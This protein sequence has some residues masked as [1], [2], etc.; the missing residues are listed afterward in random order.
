MTL[1]RIIAATILLNYSAQIDHFLNILFSQKHYSPHTIS[2]YKRD[3]KL[4]LEFT[5][6]TPPPPDDITHKDCKNFIYFLHEK[7]L[8]NRSIARVVAGLRSFWNHLIEEEHTVGNPWEALPLPKAKVGLPKV[9]NENQMSD[10]LESIG[11]D[12][13]DKARDTCICELLYA[14]GIRISE[15]VSLNVNSINL[16]ENEIRV[17][18]KGKK[19]RIVL[20][21]GHANLILSHYISHA[22]PAFPESG[23]S[24]LFV[25][26]FGN[27]LTARS[28]QRMI[29]KYSTRLGFDEVITPHTFRHSFATDL[30]NGGADLRSIQELLGHSSLATT[31]IYTHVSSA[32]LK[33]TFKQ[34]HPRGDAS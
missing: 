29:K 3:L 24:A 30:L 11:T 14:T 20:F 5:D 32:R 1:P 23:N 13:P 26:K 18:G 6:Q 31:Q 2:S 10:F 27:R 33:E 21:G 22:R 9:I 4:F 15:L 16:A 17:Y 7:S 28:I 34:A 12:T 19:E 8:Q 25:N